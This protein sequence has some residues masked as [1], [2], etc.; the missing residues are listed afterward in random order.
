MLTSTVYDGK[1]PYPINYQAVKCFFMDYESQN[2]NEWIKFK[3]TELLPLAKTKHA[4]NPDFLELSV[5]VFVN[6][7][8]AITKAFKKMCCNG[9]VPSK[10]SSL[11][12]L[13]IQYLNQRRCKG[14]VFKKR[15]YKLIINELIN[16]KILKIE[17]KKVIV[18]LA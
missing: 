16:C 1:N 2:E 10:E 12:N 17:G 18:N 15:Y 7:F 13:I 5:G 9:S 3:E 11:R 6:D 14:V 4:L 8:I